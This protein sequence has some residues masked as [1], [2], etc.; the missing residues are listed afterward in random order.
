MSEAATTERAAVN[1]ASDPLCPL[2]PFHPATMSLGGSLKCVR[3]P[4]LFRLAGKDGGE[5]GRL[6]TFGA[7]CI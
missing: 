1:D 5:K 2:L 3:R 4:H 6:G 7:I